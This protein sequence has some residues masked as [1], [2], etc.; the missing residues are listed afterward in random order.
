MNE[1]RGG[2]IGLVVRSDVEGH[3]GLS[4]MM[5]LQ[6]QETA[7]TRHIAPCEDAQQDGGGQPEQRLRVR[8]KAAALPLAQTHQQPA[9]KDRLPC[10][11]VEEPAAWVGVVRQVKPE[12][13]RQQPKHQGQREKQARPA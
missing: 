3:P 2:E 9:D 8:E 12:D 5:H 1:P 4:Q 10:E 6:V 13:T 7:Q 11:G